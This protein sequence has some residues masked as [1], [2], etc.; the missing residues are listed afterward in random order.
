MSRRALPLAEPVEPSDGAAPR[1]WI[2][3]LTAQ[4]LLHRR[5]ALGALGVTMIAAVIDISFPLLTRVA[6]DDAT[7]GRG[8]VILTVAIAIALLGLVR[9]ACQFGRR[10]L[11]GRLSIDVQ[12]DLRLD[13]LA[14]LQRLDGRKQDEIRTGQ[15][16]P[17]SITDLQLVQGLLAMVP[18]SAGAILQFVLALL[19][20]AVS[21]THLTLPT[22][23]I[24]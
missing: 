19:V 24:E 23:R 4:C 1:G 22:K 7:A 15:V 8:D 17:R 16:V 18:L 3:R 12:H 21:Y 13:L 9:F 2:R 5:T 10:M 11:A 14:S 6:I 20:M